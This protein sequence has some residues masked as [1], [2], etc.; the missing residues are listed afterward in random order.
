MSKRYIQMLERELAWA[1][2]KAEELEQ[3]GSQSQHYWKQ[4][5]ATLELA[6]EALQTTPR[7]LQQM[8]RF[9][10]GSSLAL[11]RMEEFLS[12]GDIAA[13]RHTLGKTRRRLAQLKTAFEAVDDELPRQ[14]TWLERIFGRTKDGDV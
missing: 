12:R 1:H 7:T 9:V 14:S 3:A 2:K 5:A 13:S 10:E 11:E 8:K 6:I 4:K